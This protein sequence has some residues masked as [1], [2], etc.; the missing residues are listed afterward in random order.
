M[1][2]QLL[3]AR[4]RALWL[5]PLLCWSVNASADKVDTIV[6]GEKTTI[7]QAAQSQQRIDTLSDATQQMFQ[8]YQMELKRVEDLK[9]YNLQMERQI[10]R[11][12]DAIASTQQSIQDVAIEE[13]QIAPLMARM[14]DALADFIRLDLPFLQDERQE[15]VKFLRHTL[16]RSDVSLA[17]KFRQVMDAYNIE[18]QY[19][20][21]I[22]SYRGTLT[23]DNKPREVEFLR[24]GRIALM[25]QT[26]DGNELGVWNVK[27]QAWEPLDGSYRKDIRLG[28]KIARKQAAPELLTL[29]IAAP[30]ALK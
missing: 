12:K 17:E 9:V 3:H 1:K 10:E 15:R 14:I 29:P 18:V 25:Y 19:G 28:L 16:D 11:Q 24:V 30:E 21:T 5:V 27:K 7:Q 6:N 13:R 22:E 23:L 4:S 26:L 20:N 2:W 8:Q